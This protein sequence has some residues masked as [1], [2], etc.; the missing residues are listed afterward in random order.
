MSSVEYAL[1]SEATEDRQRTDGKGWPVATLITSECLNK[2][3]NLEAFSWK[4][5]QPV[6]RVQNTISE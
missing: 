3:S 5:R 1:G 2:V 6:L 4:G